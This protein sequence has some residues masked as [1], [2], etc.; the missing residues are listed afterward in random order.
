M[1]HIHHTN[2]FVLESRP[3]GEGNKLVKLYTK[4]LGLLMGTAQSVREIRSKVRYAV[5]DYSLARV[6]LVR[7]KEFWRITSATPIA[8]S[9][10]L[11]AKNLKLLGRVFS[12]VE[13]LCAGEE[14]NEVLFDDLESFYNSL[15]SISGDNERDQLELITI[16]RVLYHLGYLGHDETTSGLL[17]GGLSISLWND[18]VFE[19]SS[20]VKKINSALRETQ[21]I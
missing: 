13:K 9:F 16:L 8:S 2:A 15:S 10:G 3:K 11:S 21:L 12:L 7:G 18:E 20:I 14:T 4:E 17:S 19:R 5:Q 1:H 6:D